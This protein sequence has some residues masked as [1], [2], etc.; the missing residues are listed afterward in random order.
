[1]FDLTIPVSSARLADVIIGADEMIGTALG[2]LKLAEQLTT[3]AAVLAGIA[4]FQA[5]VGKG[6]RRACGTLTEV[7]A[8]LKGRRWQGRGTNIGLPSLQTPEQLTRFAMAGL[9]KQQGGTILTRKSETVTTMGVLS[10]VNKAK[11]AGLNNETIMDAIIGQGDAQGA[12]DSLV[13]AI[14]QATP[15]AD[16]VKPEVAETETTETTTK[17]TTDADLVQSVLSILGGWKYDGTAN[18]EAIFDKVAEIAGANIPAT[19]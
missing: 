18:I 10:Q 2:N 8:M 7:S 5:P 19:V 16:K 13:R 9:V 6:G 14:S 1:M 3:E 12:Y 11:V 17:V 15:K 4:Y